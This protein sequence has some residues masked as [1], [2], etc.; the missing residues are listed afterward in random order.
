M[1]TERLDQLF[2]MG[3]RFNGESYVG[4]TDGMKDINFH[5]TEILCDS[6]SQWERRIISVTEEI[7]RRKN[8]TKL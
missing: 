4:I 2:E 3:L 8:L 6:D 1:K 7:K 5:H